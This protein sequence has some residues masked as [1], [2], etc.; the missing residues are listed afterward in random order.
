MCQHRSRKNRVISQ[1][2]IDRRGWLAHWAQKRRR[3]QA[4]TLGI[5]LTSDGHGRLSWTA[6]GPAKYGYSISYSTDHSTWIDN[7]YVT[8]QLSLDCHGLAGYY[9]VAKASAANGVVLPF[10]NGVYSDGL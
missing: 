10:S 9:R 7:Y 1:P 3:K 4:A 5:L 6:N 2:K 8:D